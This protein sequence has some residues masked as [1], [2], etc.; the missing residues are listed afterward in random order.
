[1]RC[2]NINFSTYVI[3]DARVGDLY[4]ETSV[5]EKRPTN[6]QVQGFFLTW[7]SPRYVLIIRPRQRGQSYIITPPRSRYARD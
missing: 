3:P 7:S 6:E 1:M 4:F 2:E 5:A